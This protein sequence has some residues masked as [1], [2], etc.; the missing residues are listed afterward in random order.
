MRDL[1]ET[2]R[3]LGMKAPTQT[4]SKNKIRQALMVLGFEEDLGNSHPTEISENLS[5]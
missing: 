4:V 1:F 5:G 2:V 3:E